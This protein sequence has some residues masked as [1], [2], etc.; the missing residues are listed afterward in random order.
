MGNERGEYNGHPTITI[1]EGEVRGRFPFTFGIKKAKLILDNL[2]EIER[3]VREN[4]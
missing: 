1:F 3:F 4:N 2:G